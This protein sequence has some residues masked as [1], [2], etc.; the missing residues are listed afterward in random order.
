MKQSRAFIIIVWKIAKISLNVAFINPY[1]TV[2]NCTHSSAVSAS[3]F[4]GL[5]FSLTG[6]K[7]W[8]EDNFMY[9]LGI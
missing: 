6:P 2:E 4:G 1:K 5:A 7:N 3:D 8:G 9:L